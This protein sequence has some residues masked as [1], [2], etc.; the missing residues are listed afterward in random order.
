MALMGVAFG[1]L[2]A[3]GLWLVF[4]RSEPLMILERVDRQVTIRSACSILPR[5]WKRGV[6]WRSRPTWLFFAVLFLQ[7]VPLDLRAYL[8]MWINKWNFSI[9]FSTSK[10]IEDRAFSSRPSSFLF[11]IA[12]FVLRRGVWFWSA[13]WPIHLFRCHL[14][15]VLC[16]CLSEVWETRVQC[17]IFA[18]LSSSL[19][20][21]FIVD[22]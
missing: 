21:S 11:C 3:V 15:P 20:S 6:S 12:C 9:Y 18:A 13:P 5:N 7:E 22:D 16:A 1:I 8:K 10:F 14:W 4:F 2:L 19:P 17:V